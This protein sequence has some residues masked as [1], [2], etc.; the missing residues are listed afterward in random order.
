MN[1][2]LNPSERVPAKGCNGF[3]LINRLA[4][5][6]NGKTGRKIKLY[7]NGRGYF[8]FKDSCN[9]V[10]KHRSVARI[11]ALTYVP[12]PYNLPTVNHING[13]KTDNRP[14]NLEWC[15][16]KRQREHAR[17]VLGRKMGYQKGH[18]K[19]KGSGKQPRP[20]R[21]THLQTGEEREFESTHEAAR[22]VGGYQ[23]GIVAACQ[24]K[25]KSSAGYR[26]EYL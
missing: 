25:L 23:Q 10:A 4:E 8:Y 5:I 15:T 17:D 22:Q 6:F 19:C 21:G 3:Y 1:I 9:G 2:V 14:E 16:Y 7:L 26:W 13:D 18:R 11:S 20:V 24:G 12:N